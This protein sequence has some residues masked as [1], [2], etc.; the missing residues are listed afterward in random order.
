MNL[1]LIFALYYRGPIMQMKKQNMNRLT[2]L[3]S[4]NIPSHHDVTP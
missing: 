2:L 1:T 3:P 4:I